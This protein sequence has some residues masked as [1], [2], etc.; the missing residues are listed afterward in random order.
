MKRLICSLLI[1]FSLL[2]TAFGGPL[3]DYDSYRDAES[4]T[5][6]S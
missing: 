6:I 4:H 2:P 3:L 5:I 1:V